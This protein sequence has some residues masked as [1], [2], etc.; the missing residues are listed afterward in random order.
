MSK[1]TQVKQ[2]KKTQQD[3]SE[4]DEWAKKLV[5]KPTPQI[6]VLQNSSGS[7]APIFGTQS[8]SSLTSQGIPS[9]WG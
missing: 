8:N 2:E 5:E 3:D 6:G 1:T 4:Y 7:T 9:N